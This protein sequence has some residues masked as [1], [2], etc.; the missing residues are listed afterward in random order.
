MILDVSIARTWSC[1][2]HGKD[3]RGGSV[4]D[5]RVSI[6]KGQRSKMYT[7]RYRYP[8]FSYS[9]GAAVVVRCYS[10]QYYHYCCYCRVLPIGTMPN[11]NKDTDVFRRGDNNTRVARQHRRRGLHGSGPRRATLT[12][13]RSLLLLLLLI[14]QLLRPTLSAL[15]NNKPLLV[16]GLPTE[17]AHRAESRSRC[18]STEQ[19]RCARACRMP[20]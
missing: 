14:F 3:A 6:S 16:G 18:L 7:V 5:S 4:V 15:S 1:I 11:L 17:Q 19:C 13:T 10:L 2:E 12:P 8:R 9:G 20:R